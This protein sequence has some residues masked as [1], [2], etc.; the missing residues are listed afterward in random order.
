MSILLPENAFETLKHDGFLLLK[1]PKGPTEAIQDTCSLAC[2][3]FRDRLEEKVTSSLPSDLGYRSLAGEYSQSPNRPDQYE[4]FSAS[5]RMRSAVTSLQSKTAKDLYNAMLNVIGE[6][7][8]IAESVTSTIAKA[9]NN[10]VNSDGFSGAFHLWS[11]LQFNYAQPSLTKAE[12]INDLHEDGCLLTIACPMVPGLEIRT[13][14]GQFMRVTTEPDEI[15]VFPGEIL[16]LLSGGVLLPLHHR[17]RPNSKY[18]ER[19]SLL[20]F[21]DIDPCLCLPWRVNEINRTVD[22]GKRVRENPT[23]FGLAEWDWE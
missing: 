10:T 2:R 12:F 6:F 18:E 23:R 3:F 14:G 21:A 19:L 20:Y 22:I 5:A 15:L 7:E 9:I 11:F 8:P 13:M 16:W 1:I 4:S 17:V